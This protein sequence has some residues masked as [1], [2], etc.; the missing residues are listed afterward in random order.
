MRKCVFL[1]VSVL[2]LTGGCGVKPKP[3]FTKEEL[4][5]M[6]F[7]QGTGLPQSSGGFVLAVGDRTISDKEIVSHLLEDLRPTAQSNT[8]AQFE[9]QARE[10]V[11]QVITTKI[12]N[13]LLYREARKHGDEGT[14]EAVEKLT[15]A[16]MRRFFAGFGND[17]TKANEALKQMR[18]NRQSYREYV[19]MTI[20]IQSYSASRVPSNVPITYSELVDYYNQMKDQ[21][22]ARPAKIRFRLLDIDIA[23]LE[24][25]DRN[26]DRR[27]FARNKADNF[28]RQIQ[29]GEDPGKLE[30][31][32]SG[33][34][35]SDH[36]NGVRPESLREPYDILAVEAEK[37]RPGE[38][39]AVVSE[40]GERIFV[41]KL[42][43]KEL[44]GYKPLE[45]VQE[46]LEDKIIADRRQKAVDEL[47]AKLLRQVPVSER[48]AFVD[49][50]LKKI[51]R[52]SNHRQVES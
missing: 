52:V 35:F 37:M 28:V 21:F 2:L 50:C 41:I 13:L 14:M 23:A 24:V 46:Q 36:S 38:T 17:L 7:P 16:E 6:P 27:Q 10:Q 33:I 40:T 44:K 15:E 31:K 47:Q 30:D 48:N 5:R 51:Y 8:F 39:R 29:V 25:T 9:E 3:R 45:E 49:L 22:F 20:F 11:E 34:W 12:L 19:K 42:D 32:A 1:F 4:E 43:G 26:Q 18:M